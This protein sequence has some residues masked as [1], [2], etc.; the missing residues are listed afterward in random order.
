[1]LINRRKTKSIFRN[2]KSKE[3]ISQIWWLKKVYQS[4]LR[5]KNLALAKIIELENYQ[6][7]KNFTFHERSLLKS[8]SRDSVLKKLIDMIA[9]SK[10]SEAIVVGLK[11][12]INDR[13][14][15]SRSI[16]RD[17]LRNEILIRAID[18]DFNIAQLIDVVK[19]LSVCR[20]PTYQEA[21]DLLWISFK[22]RE[23]DI[24]PENI[25]TLFKTLNLFKESKVMLSTILTNK[26]RLIYP[27]LSGSQMADILD[28]FHQNLFPSENLSQ[29]VKNIA[30][31]W[32][33]NYSAIGKN[34]DLSEILDSLKNLNHV[35]ETMVLALENLVKIKGNKIEDARLVSAIMKYCM[36]VRVE[37]STLQE[38][39]IGY[40]ISKGKDLPEY[41]FSSILAPI[42][43]FPNSSQKTAT[44]FEVLT[45]ILISRF[46]K[47]DSQNTLDILLTYIYAEQ[48]PE[49]LIDEKFET[50]MRRVLK[51]NNKLTKSIRKK[52]LIF[53]SVMALECEK[54][55]KRKFGWIE[56]EDQKQTLPDLRIRKIINKIKVQ[57]SSLVGGPEKIGVG[58]MLGGLP[59]IDF[60]NVDIIVYPTSIRSPIVNLKSEKI[61][62]LCAILIHL[63]E[64]L[65]F[66]T[67][68]LIGPQMMRMRILRKLGF[69][70]ASLD[71]EILL[72]MKQYSIEMTNYLAKQ[73]S[74][75]K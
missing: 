20:D 64:H 62:N 57:L 66:G 33:K 23:E 54:Y 65:C 50:R 72:E 32:M 60:Y 47:L 35:D 71:Y 53:D 39:L 58:M 7:Q 11:I 63:P 6:Y 10:D 42:G 22:I 18:G 46:S 37:N 12:V 73:I 41:Y 15:P 74:D 40:F 25:V 28:V 67:K 26:L 68:N 27:K 17:R 70:I 31:E 45:E 8:E 38:F 52:L 36:K 13:V 59:P 30:S 29:N 14:S 21:I 16:Y 56:K 49:K 69:Q 5:I 43:F 61:E 3:R 55:G 24:S 75:A 34:E 1:M 2:Q 48:Y 19:T 44:V 51:K 9:R 4:Q